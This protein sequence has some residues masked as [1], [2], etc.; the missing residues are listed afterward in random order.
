MSRVSRTSQPHDP[1]SAMAVS[2]FLRSLADRAQSDPAFA[3][4]VHAAL[5]ESG[6]LSV[7]P[8]SPAAPAAPAAPTR[9]SSRAVASP[10]GSV[11][12]P[13]VPAAPPAHNPPAPALDPF[14]VLRQRGDSALRSA[15]ED[16]DLAALRQLVRTHRLDPARIS[17]RWSARDRVIALIVDQVRARADH[18]KAFSRV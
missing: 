14:A 6:L 15:L 12:A 16:L 13:A 10:A 1:D 9:R 11:G 18:G 8:A 7:S 5:R 4:Q 3:T 17:A 2:A